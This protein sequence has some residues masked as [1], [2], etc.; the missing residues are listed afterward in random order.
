MREEFVSYEVD[1]A[2]TGRELWMAQDLIGM[3]S[4]LPNGWWSI[5]SS[6]RS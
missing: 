4:E 6:Q 3:V 1:R 5:I 2:L